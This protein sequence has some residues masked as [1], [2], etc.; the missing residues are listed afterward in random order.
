MN[1]VC[2]TFTVC[3]VSALF[4]CVLIPFLKYYRIDDLHEHD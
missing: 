1:T 4:V 3:V 2:Y